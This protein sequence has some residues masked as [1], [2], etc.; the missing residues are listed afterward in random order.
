[1]PLPDSLARLNRRVTNPA[2][3]PLA[4]RLPY[5]GV[6]LHRGRHTG[7]LYR[8]PVNAFPQRDGFVVALTYGRDVDWLKNVLATDGC[9]L[10]HRGRPVDLADPQILP[11]EDAPAIPTAIRGLLRGIGVSEA[12]HLEV[13]PP[14]EGGG[15]A[16]GVHRHDGR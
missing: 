9:R 12:V 8:T 5:F 15:V 7:R 10:I 14:H 1:M 6:V 4:G 11:L 16:D 13:G 3:R 2:L